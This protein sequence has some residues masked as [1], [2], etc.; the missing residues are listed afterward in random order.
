[1]L[2]QQWCIIPCR[3]SN[4]AMARPLQGANSEDGKLSDHLAQWGRYR[5][6]TSLQRFSMEPGDCYYLDRGM[7]PF[8]FTILGG[9]S[10]RNYGERDHQSKRCDQRALGRRQGVPQ[11]KRDC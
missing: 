3:G 7:L 8:G 5:V 9:F 2:T 1:M 4:M 10:R 11:W 6:E